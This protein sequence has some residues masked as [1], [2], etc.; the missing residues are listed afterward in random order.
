MPNTK[1]S[2]PFSAHASILL[3]AASIVAIVIFIGTVFFVR[4]KLLMQ[5]QI[6]DKLR[7]TAAAAAM[8]FDGDVIDTILT[9]DDTKS[10][11]FQDI[12]MRLN[13]LREEIPNIKFAY[14]MRKTDNPNI[15]SFVADADQLLSIEELDTNG[16]GLIDAD[17]KPAGTGD[18]YDISEIPVMKTDA[19]LRPSVDVESSLDQWGELISGYAPILNTAGRVVAIL[20]LDMD[21]HDYKTISQSIFSPVAFL[22]IILAAVIMGGSIFLYFTRRQIEDIH[23]MEEERSGLLRLTFHQLGGPLTIMNWS[24]EM[25]KDR[26]EGESI[27]TYVGNIEEAMGRLA[28]VLNSL[29]DADQ[30]REGTMLYQAESSSLHAVIESVKNECAARLKKTGQRIEVHMQDENL[31]MHLD[32]KLISG[33]LRELLTNALDFSPPGSLTTV[34]VRKENGFATVSVHDEGYGIPQS[35]LHRLFEQFTRGSNA[36]KYKPD[37]GG[38]GLYIVKGIVERA[39]GTIWIESKEGEGTTVTFRLPIG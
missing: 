30:I 22:L 38:L 15:L 14:I 20:G 18:L 2:S 13:T 35:D 25:L 3:Y 19:F 39:G 16:N 36:T 29:R 23:I 4:G 33:V 6:K 31:E 17:E 37:G 1:H 10:E 5:V 11:S 9:Q 24:L 7:S 34:N 32:K 28:I 27:D 26:R 21:A 8:Q 12:I